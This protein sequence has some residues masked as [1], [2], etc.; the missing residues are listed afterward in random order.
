MNADEYEQY[1]EITKTIIRNGGASQENIDKNPYIEM[2]LIKRA[3]IISGC[4]EKVPKLVEVMKPYRNGN[5]IGRD[6]ALA[7]N[8]AIPVSSVNAFIEQAKAKEEVEVSLNFQ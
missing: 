7:M 3:R 1:Q 5:Y 8:Y 2:L 6:D 4:K